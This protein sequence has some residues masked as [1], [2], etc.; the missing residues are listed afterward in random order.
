V[1]LSFHLMWPNLEDAQIASPPAVLT[2]N[3][4]AIGIQKQPVNGCTDKKG[5]QVGKAMFSQ[6]ISRNKGS[7]RALALI[8]TAGP[9]RHDPGS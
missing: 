1:S 2:Q 6:H 4:L 7:P 9:S 8:E 3:L 5:D